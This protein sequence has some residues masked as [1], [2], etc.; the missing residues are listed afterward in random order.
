MWRGGSSGTKSRQSATM[1]GSL[2][3]CREGTVTHPSTAAGVRHFGREPGDGGCMHPARSLDEGERHAMTTR[4]CC[5]LWVAVNMA[6]TPSTEPPS[7]GRKYST[8]G[9]NL[10]Q[11]SSDAGHLLA[12]VRVCCYDTTWSG[13]T[14]EE[15]PS[16]VVDSPEPIVNINRTSNGP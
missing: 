14:A 4:A 9:K 6:I 10:V 8:G 13:S 15:R 2:Q 12:G 11:T 1:P 3:P 7:H 5:G 16:G